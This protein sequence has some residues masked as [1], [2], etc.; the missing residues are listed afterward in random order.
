MSDVT[1][2]QAVQRLIDDAGI[3]SSWAELDSTEQAE[4]RQQIEAKLEAIAR[5]APQD[6]HGGAR[7]VAGRW[8]FRIGGTLWPLL[9]FLVKLAFA[10]HD[11]TGLTWK[12]AIKSAI[13][14][15]GSLAGV[16]HQLD[17]T[18]QLICAAIARKRLENRQAGLQPDGANRQDIVNA[19]AANQQQPPVTLDESLKALLDKKIIA[20]EDDPKRGGLYR[21]SF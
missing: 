6:E 21:I 4:M 15:L 8:S 14:L 19:F 18:Q 16:V 9:V 13:E 7:I 5:A 20:R 1:G 12:A 17:P 2:Q 3:A 10:S 11:P